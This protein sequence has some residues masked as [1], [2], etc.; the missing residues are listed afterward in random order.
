VWCTDHLSGLCQRAL[1][2]C[3]SQELGE[4]EIGDFHVTLGADED[5]LG[6]DV[7]MHDTLIMS[8]LQR[9]ADLGNHRQRGFRFKLF[10]MD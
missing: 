1:L 5:I 7:T 3:V 4:S 10:G 8:V 9:V 6:F 2:H